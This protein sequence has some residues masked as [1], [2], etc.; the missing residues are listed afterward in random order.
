MAYV[1]EH[2]SSNLE[3]FKDGLIDLASFKERYKDKKL[4]EI[5]RVFNRSLPQTAYIDY[6]QY[7]VKN[8]NRGEFV[9]DKQ[10]IDVHGSG[11]GLITVARGE[12]ELVINSMVLP[13]SMEMIENIDRYFDLFREKKMGN[14]TTDEDIHSVMGMSAVI[15]VL[16]GALHPFADGNGRTSLAL[17]GYTVASASIS[18][19]GLKLDLKKIGA[20]SRHRRYMVLTGLSFSPRPYLIDEMI[21]RVHGNKGS[22]DIMYDLQAINR[23]DEYLEGF[24]VNMKTFIEGV[25]W[26]TGEV[27]LDEEKFPSAKWMEI[28]LKGLREIF[29]EAL[30]VKSL[31]Q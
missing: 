19:G 31:V 9:K 4:S 5:A 3:T 24:L 25:N 23:L 30:I 10:Y 7:D 17:A 28:G 26:E 18:G 1:P 27:A 20:D 22:I 29:T 6:R 15:T 14:V 8:R 13:R 2:F 11:G 12:R 16:Y 21:G